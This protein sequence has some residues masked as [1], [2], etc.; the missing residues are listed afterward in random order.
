MPLDTRVN[1]LGVLTRLNLLFIFRVENGED[2]G[3][4]NLGLIHIRHEVR[5]IADSDTSEKDL[6]DC[7]ENV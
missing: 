3:C 7:S 6:I 4:G 1:H 2:V 5:I